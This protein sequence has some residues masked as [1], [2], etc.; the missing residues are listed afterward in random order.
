MQGE[1]LTKK[2]IY[3]RISKEDR[4]AC[5][6][7][8][9]HSIE[10]QNTWAHRAAELADY[11]AGVRGTMAERAKTLRAQIERDRRAVNVMRHI[12]NLDGD[13]VV[14]GLSTPPQDLRDLI[15]R[16]MVAYCR[17]HRRFSVTMIGYAVSMLW[18]LTEF[19]LARIE[20]Q[21]RVRKILRTAMERMQARRPGDGG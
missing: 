16:E 21:I 4:P 14:V 5:A 20:H 19:E 18:M 7:G 12:G 9:F 11:G 6:C 2:I 3:V 10:A 17:E 8:L 1:A 15:S 13:A